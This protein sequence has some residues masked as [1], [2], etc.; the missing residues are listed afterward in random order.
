M[1]RCGSINIVWV[2][3]FAMQ[4]FRENGSVMGWLSVV[5]QGLDVVSAAPGLSALLTSVWVLVLGC[6]SCLLL[7]VYVC[8]RGGAVRFDK[9]LSVAKS[10]LSYGG[11]V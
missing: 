8:L 7:V 4:G 10:E 6:R 3:V 11:A 1:R 2:H 9:L 5:L